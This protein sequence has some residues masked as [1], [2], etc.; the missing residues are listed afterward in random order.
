MASTSPTPDRHGYIGVFR[1][2]VVDKRR[3]VHVALFVLVLLAIQHW[4]DDFRD[5]VDA[6]EHSPV[7]VRIGHAGSV[8]WQRGVRITN[9]VQTGIVNSITRFGD[10]S[11]RFRAVTQRAQRV[12]SWFTPRFRREPHKP[13]PRDRKQPPGQPSSASTGP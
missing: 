12:V 8:M 2:I 13:P 4:P 5:R 1:E 10:P 6:I 9:A 3:V 7:A 11:E